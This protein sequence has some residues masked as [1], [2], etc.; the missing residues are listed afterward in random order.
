MKTVKITFDIDAS[1]AAVVIEALDSS[2]HKWK[3]GSSKD[4]LVLEEQVKCRRYATTCHKYART[5]ET[6]FRAGGKE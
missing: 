2:S 4:H 3:E 5:I 1:D 6:Q